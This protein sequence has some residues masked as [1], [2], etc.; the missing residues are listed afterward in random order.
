M[1]KRK[2]IVGWIDKK[3]FKLEY[4]ITLTVT[5]YI[6]IDFKERMKAVLMPLADLE[7]ER[8]DYEAQLE[9]AAKQLI[10]RDCPGCP[11][12]E[13]NNLSCKLTAEQCGK[14]W[15]KYLKSIRAK[16]VTR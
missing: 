8:A 11:N 6:G 13:E 2:M 10:N 3:D 12:W 16:D 1:T 5:K 15:L 4:P 14:W 9:E 7:R